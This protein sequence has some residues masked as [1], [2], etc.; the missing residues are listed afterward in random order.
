MEKSMSR[1]LKRRCESA[2]VSAESV[3]YEV[4]E[5]VRN[6]PVTSYCAFTDT[7]VP[8]S[9]EARMKQGSKKSWPI[10]P[11]FLFAV[12]FSL[13]MNPCLI[14]AKAGGPT[15]DGNMPGAGLVK[16]QKNK[17]RWK[18]KHGGCPE[19]NSH[20]ECRNAKQNTGGNQEKTVH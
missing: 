15:F 17:D 10:L 13:A 1:I 14:F 16:I 18:R 8:C 20:C 5:T 11:V 6:R 4:L 7:F 2:L 19:N 9:L 3:Q 12:C